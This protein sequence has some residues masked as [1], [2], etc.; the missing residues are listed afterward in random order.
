MIGVN[1]IIAVEAAL[2]GFEKGRSVQI[3]Y[4]QVR[5]IGN[6]RLRILKAERPIE[7]NPIG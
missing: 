5:Q 2:D 6:D 4:T 7:L 3:G 1:H